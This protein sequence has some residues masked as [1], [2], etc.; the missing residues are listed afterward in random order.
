MSPRRVNCSRHLPFRAPDIALERDSSEEEPCDASIAGTGDD[1]AG[2]D[3]G[4]WLRVF[5]GED[6]SRS[7]QSVGFNQFDLASFDSS[8]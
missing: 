2:E 7:R 5:Q 1:L 6:T 4:D 8:Y 3:G